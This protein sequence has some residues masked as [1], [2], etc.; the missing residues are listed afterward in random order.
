MR[1]STNSLQDRRIHPMRDLTVTNTPAVQRSLLGYR[2]TLVT[3]SRP[4]D[5]RDADSFYDDT[6]ALVMKKSTESSFREYSRT[7]RAAA[8][9]VQMRVSRPVTAITT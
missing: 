9:H 3:D 7:P 5:F 4:S 6:L 1:L 2:R 8:Y